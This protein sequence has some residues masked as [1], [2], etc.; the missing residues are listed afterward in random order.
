M[1]TPSRNVPSTSAPANA[2]TPVS[3]WVNKSISSRIPVSA[4]LAGRRRRSA[5]TNGTRKA[6]MKEKPLGSSQTD[7]NLTEIVPR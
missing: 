5:R 3:D 1:I 2:K 7:P 6:I 4:T